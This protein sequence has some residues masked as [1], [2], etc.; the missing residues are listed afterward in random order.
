MAATPI[1]GN[2]PAN[3]ILGLLLGDDY[4]INWAWIEADSGAPVPMPGYAGELVLLNAASAEVLR[5][6]TGNGRLVLGS[7]D[8]T[9]TGLITKAE[10]DALPSSGAWHLRLIT[11]GGIRDTKAAGRFQVKEP[12]KGGATQLAVIQAGAG[13]VLSAAGATRVEILEI[14]KVGPKGQDGEAASAYP[15]IQQTPATCWVINHGLGYRPS[16]SL[17]DSAGKEIVGLVLHIDSVQARAYFN[18]PV[19]GAARCT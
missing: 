7:T 18:A 5:L 17:V 2:Q 6:D 8:G 14:A 11:T 3:F 4:P 12:G 19:A 9:I 10:I 13:R 15:H 16:V 1:V